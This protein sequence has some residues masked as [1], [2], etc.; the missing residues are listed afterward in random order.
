LRYSA[1]AWQARL[2]AL[3]L[4]GAAAAAAAGGAAAAPAWQA[5]LAALRLEGVVAAAAAAGAVVTS[6]VFC[7]L[8]LYL[9]EPVTSWLETALYEPA[10]Q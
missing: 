2:A 6:C 9:W 1:P 5:K 8:L 10:Q 7:M 3:R 4:G